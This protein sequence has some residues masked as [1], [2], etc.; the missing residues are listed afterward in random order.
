MIEEPILKKKKHFSKKYLFFSIITLFMFGGISYGLIFFYQEYQG[1]SM[2]MTTDILTV[3]I[4]EDGYVAIDGATGQK[5][6]DALENNPRTGFRITNNSPT[7]IKIKV[8]LV[9]DSTSTMDSNQV[10]FAINK[11][12][13]GIINLGNLGENNNVLGEIYIGSGIEVELSSTIWL[14]YYYTGSGEKFSAKYKVEVMNSDE[15]ANT[16]LTSLVGKNKGLYAINSDGTLNDGTNVTNISEYRYSGKNPD[17]Y[18]KFNN[19]LWR[20]IGID[21]YGFIKIVKDES[22]DPS[23]FGIDNYYENSTVESVLYEYLGNSINYEMSEMLHR[24][25]MHE[26]ISVNLNDTYNLIEYDFVNQ[27]FAGLLTA[28]DYLYST[29][30][31]YY[32]SPLSDINV[33]NNTWLSGSYLTMTSIKNTTTNVL[34]INNNV[35][36]SVLSTDENYPLKPCIFLN[37][38]VSIVSGNGTIDK[39]YE[40]AIIN[41]RTGDDSYAPGE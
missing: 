11:Y 34:A 23:E 27:A 36:T 25:G 18:I 10:R 32:T 20:I 26:M 29:E 31:K 21:K 13:G 7:P 22:L 38:N 37:F 3:D 15:Y 16:Y 1:S 24:Y 9:E 6:E 12:W 17:N 14:D 4:T 5:D 39:P 19:E 40:I 2:G 28:K 33:G 8:S 30:P 41:Q 35:P